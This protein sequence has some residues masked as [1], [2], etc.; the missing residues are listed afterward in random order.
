[1]RRKGERADRSGDHVEVVLGA[2]DDV[3]RR[4]RRASGSTGT[5][6]HDDTADLTQ[7]G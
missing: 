2:H 3:G 7:H 4:V 6:L 5:D 1:V